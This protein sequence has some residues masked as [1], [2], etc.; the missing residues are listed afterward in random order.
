MGE[1]H[2][3][4]LQADNHLGR[5]APSVA[6]AAERAGSLARQAACATKTTRLGVGPA[7]LGPGGPCGEHVPQCA[8]FEAVLTLEMR[9]TIIIYFRSR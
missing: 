8:M 7:A 9:N 3:P 4:A 2:N 6:R 5:C 1:P